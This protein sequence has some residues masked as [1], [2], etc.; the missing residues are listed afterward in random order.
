M[1]CG[2]DFAA[3]WTHPGVPH[4]YALTWYNSYLP[5]SFKRRNT[6]I[7]YWNFMRF[8]FRTLISQSDIINS[9]VKQKTW[10]ITYL[11][12]RLRSKVIEIIDIFWHLVSIYCSTICFEMQLWKDPHKIII[13]EHLKILPVVGFPCSQVVS[14]NQRKFEF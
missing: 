3:K 6:R 4:Y 11:H 8:W 5:Q 2:P 9:Y 13:F 10:Y 1:Q 7:K 12:Q 14:K